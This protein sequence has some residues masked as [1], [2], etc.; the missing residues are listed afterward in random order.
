MY[1]EDFLDKAVKDDTSINFKLRQK[2][3]ADA[4]LKLDKNYEKYRIP[5]N[6]TWSD[7]KFYKQ[8]TIEL[9][10]SGDTGSLIRNAVTGVRYNF[11]V[12][13][14][15]EDL[16]FKVSDCTGR[17]GRRNPLILFYDSPEQYENHQFTVVSPK[18]KQK[19]YEKS[20]EAQKRLNM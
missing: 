6:K 1:Y 13:C 18:I 14:I 12:G 17:N 10:G 4:I 20:G 9:Y 5:V 16:L 15:Y 3:P 19:W 7:G 11:E 8:V 2:Q